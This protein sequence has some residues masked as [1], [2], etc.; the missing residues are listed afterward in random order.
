MAADRPPRRSRMLLLVCACLA[1][2]AHAHGGPAEA[3]ALLRRVL[4]HDAVP[5]FTVELHDGAGTAVFE[6]RTRPCAFNSSETCVELLG[7]DPVG[8]AAGLHHYL[9]R[10][11]LRSSSWAGGSLG[12]LPMPRPLPAVRTPVSARRWSEWTYYGNQVTPSYS[13]AWWT[14]ERWEQELDWMAMRG[15]TLLATLGGQEEL[16]WRV[17]GRLGLSDTELQRWLTGPAFHA[18]GRMGNL[19]GW[20]GPLPRPLARAQLALHARVVRR[21]R[22]LGMHPVLPCFAGHVPSAVTRVFP[23]A[24]VV[25]QPD[26]CG[27]GETYSEAFFL[28]PTDPLYA[29]LAR[30]LIHEQARAGLLE[31]ERTGADGSGSAAAAGAGGTGLA[32]STQLYACDQFNEVRPTGRSASRGLR[33]LREA[34]GAHIRALTRADPGA[35]WML[36]AWQFLDISFWSARRRRAYLGAVPR[37]RLLVLDLY[38]EV[39]PLWRQTEAFGGHPFVWCMLHNFGANSGLY[40]KLPTV[41]T[42]PRADAAEAARLWGGRVAGVG[43]CMEGTGTTEAAYDALFDA[44][45]DLDGAGGAAADVAHAADPTAAWLDRWVAARYGSAR[46]DRPFRAWQQLRRTLLSADSSLDAEVQGAPVSIMTRRPAL[47][48]ERSGFQPTKLFYDPAE[49]LP[50]WELLLGAATDACAPAAEAPAVTAERGDAARGRPSG[51]AAA[52][53]ACPPT[54]VHDLLDVSRQVLSNL[55]LPLHRQLVAAYGDADAAAVRRV[56]ARMLRLMRDL[57]A[58]LG[59]ARGW[60]LGRWLADAR[61]LASGLEQRAELEAMLEWNARNQVTLWGPAG[62]VADYACKEW[63]GLIRSYYVPRWELFVRALEAA[64]RAQ[65]A[66]DT[67]AFARECLSLERAWQHNSSER[68]SSEPVADDGTRLMSPVVEA[69][70]RLHDQYSLTTRV[71]IST[72]D[73]RE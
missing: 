68:F 63:A 15:V 20:G 46:D 31:L 11:A 35:V 40:A 59:T 18:W 43:V 9:T 54:L 13:Q 72:H 62:E 52:R 14:W 2:R 32:P 37:G 66:F 28:E 50:A 24:S 56:G 33:G 12:A 17:Y 3:L 27:F 7:A 41:L 61:E 30:E 51:G 29:R 1:L 55:M 6:V 44:Q 67:D 70:A 42:A 39:R 21:A 49:L 4:P 65:S 71:A 23:N 47:S 10:Y 38:A 57:D 8:V 58:A 5:Y 34:S 25:R 26:W 60:L 53:P 19:R 48:M 45:W 69:V 73:A 16:W 36:Q 22:A 64:A